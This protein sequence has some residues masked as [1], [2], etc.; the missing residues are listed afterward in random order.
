MTW[1]PHWVWWVRMLE[2]SDAEIQAQ[3]KRLAW[4]F[5][6]LSNRIERRWRGR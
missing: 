3:A 1:E 2:P 4:Q 6:K 5:E